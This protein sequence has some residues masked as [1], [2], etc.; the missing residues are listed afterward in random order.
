MQNVKK[1]FIVGNRRSGT[2]L[3]L[4]LFDDHPD[5]VVFPIE[6]QFFKLS[7]RGI[8][9]KKY[10]LN[11]LLKKL[12][13]A[14]INPEPIVSRLEK[15]PAKNNKEL[16]LN[17][18]KALDKKG[19][20]LIEKTPVHRQFIPYIIKWFPDAI[21]LHVNRNVY[22]TYASIKKLDQLKG[23]PSKISPEEFVLA[24]KHAVQVAQGYE[25]SVHYIQYEDL[26]KTTEKVMRNLCKLLE[27]EYKSILLQPTVLGRP[28]KANSA[29][30]NTMSNVHTNSIQHGK[31]LNTKDKRAIDKAYRIPE[32][33]LKIIVKQKQ[34]LMRI[35]TKLKAILKK[36]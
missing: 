5:C 19:S 34:M 31:T 20:V 30:G 12:P 6:T 8:M 7:S 36:N 11:F 14:E 10:I 21:I 33:I 4:S 18:F 1:V 29:F 24:N 16:Y 23:R 28:K 15:L 2:T 32:F 35:K 22:D 13:R 17:L 9:S 27:I 3:L 26:V 25:K